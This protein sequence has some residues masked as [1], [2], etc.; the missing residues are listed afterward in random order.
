MGR[1]FGTLGI[2]GES[3]GVLWLLCRCD[4]KVK[5]EGDEKVK[6]E[7]GTLGMAVLCFGS[8]QYL[9]YLL[10]KFYYM[11][12][13]CQFLVLLMPIFIMNTLYLSNLT[14]PLFR[15]L[16]PF[17][18]YSIWLNLLHFIELM[19]VNIQFYCHSVDKNYVAHK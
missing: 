6:R 14:T 5:R 18:I 8:P 10:L 17:D 2:A 19:A 9:L 3:I 11:S 7:V 15:K 16:T 1:E 4:E 12:I 13:P